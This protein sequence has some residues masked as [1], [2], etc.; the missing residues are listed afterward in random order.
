MKWSAL[1]ILVSEQI[2]RFSHL[3]FL[4]HRS[5]NEG[6]QWINFCH[7]FGSFLCSF[8]RLIIINRKSV[9]INRLGQTEV[10]KQSSSVCIMHELRARKTF[11]FF[12]L[13]HQRRHRSTFGK[14]KSSHR[15]DLNMFWLS[16]GQSE[17]TKKSFCMFNER[18]N[19]T[20]THI[21]RTLDIFKHNDRPDLF[22]FSFPFSSFSNIRIKMQ[23][24]LRAPVLCRLFSPRCQTAISLGEAC[25]REANKKHVVARIPAQRNT[26]WSVP[27]MDRNNWLRHCVRNMWAQGDAHRFEYHQF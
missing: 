9:E 8:G 25:E 13:F 6:N 2:G 4:K 19:S 3:R 7:L 24:K 15:A 16:P 27:V 18:S 22:S 11:I 26:E 5:A 10:H 17:R 1:G 14:K 23:T 12:L 21:H 20:R